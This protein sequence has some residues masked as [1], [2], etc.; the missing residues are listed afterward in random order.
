MSTVF[1]GWVYYIKM[2]H[3]AFVA[4]QIHTF[5]NLLASNGTMT[6]AFFS[7]PQRLKWAQQ[8]S[9]LSLRWSCMTSFIASPGVYSYYVTTHFSLSSVIVSL[10]WIVFFEFCQTTARLDT[11]ITMHLYLRA[12]VRV[13]R[14]VISNSRIQTHFPDED[15][16]TCLTSDDGSY[17]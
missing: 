11:S 2:F 14:K 15:D 12:Y 5:V 9:R 3:F 10:R 6:A 7:E 17:F 4:I 13:C 8:W 16:W 1:N